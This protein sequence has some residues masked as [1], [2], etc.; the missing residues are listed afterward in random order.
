MTAPKNGQCKLT[1]QTRNSILLQHQK[2]EGANYNPK[3]QRFQFLM[4]DTQKRN[5]KN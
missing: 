2:M 3:R 4:G 5:K 1:Q